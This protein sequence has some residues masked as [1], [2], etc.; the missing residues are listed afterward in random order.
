[1]PTTPHSEHD[2]TGELTT[3]HAYTTCTTPLLTTCIHAHRNNQQE[4]RAQQ[5]PQVTA[6]A[7]AAHAHF[8]VCLSTQYMEETALVHESVATTPGALFSCGGAAVHANHLCSLC[9]H[10]Y[11]KTGNKGAA[12]LCYA[13][14]KQEGSLASHSWPCTRQIF[15]LLTPH[16]EDRKSEFLDQ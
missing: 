4:A 8:H 11:T 6:Q 2:P 14:N 13:A 7:P 3:L 12:S 5:T 15:N 9:K 1:M 10:T 16:K